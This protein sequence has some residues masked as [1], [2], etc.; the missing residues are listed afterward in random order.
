MTLSAWTAY[1]GFDTHS[2]K[3]PKVITDVNNL[4]FEYNATSLPVTKTLDGN[5]IDVANTKYN[6]TITIAP[7]SSIVLLKN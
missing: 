1:S 7:Y 6:R 3:S 5:Y 2:Y 4:I